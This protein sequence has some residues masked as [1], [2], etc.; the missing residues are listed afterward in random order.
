MGPFLKQ[1]GGNTRAF[2]DGLAR[3]PAKK[4]EAFSRMVQGLPRR[5]GQVP[6]RSFLRA[7]TDAARPL[8]MEGARAWLRANGFPLPA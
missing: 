3:M 4:L 7:G 8:S 2:V 1:L 6:E 5:D